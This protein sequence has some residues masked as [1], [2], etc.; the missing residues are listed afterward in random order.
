[1]SDRPDG[2]PQKSSVLS[3]VLRL[4]RGDASGIAMF[5]H[6]PGSF[7]ASLV[8]LAMIPLVSALAAF[9]RGEV[10]R[11][12]TDLAAA[13]CL[14]L[15]PAVVSHVLARFWNREAFW[16]RF[17]IAYN[18]CHFGL[19][20]VGFAVLVGIG[21]A[22]GAAGAGPSVQASIAVAVLCLGILG[23]VLWLHWF[24]ARRGLGI[25]SGRAALVVLATYGASFAILMLWSPPLMVRG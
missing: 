3:G 13:T 23:Y 22:I 5:G 25:S 8:P 21:I 9:A 19:T 11:A 4:A 18:W 17:V 6:T 10:Y 2:Q 20:V 7:L 24:V 1:M 14:L 15:V 12:L 16:L